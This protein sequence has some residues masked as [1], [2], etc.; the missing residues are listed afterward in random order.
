[1][2]E[3]IVQNLSAPG[4]LAIGDYVF[5]SRWG[6]C[7]WC[8]PW[9]VGHVSEIGLGW[10]SLGE[11]GARRFPKAMR[12][13]HSQGAAI[14]AAYPGLEREKAPLDYEVVAKV[15]GVSRQACEPV[16]AQAEIARLRSALGGLVREYEGYFEGAPESASLTT[17]REALRT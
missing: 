13:T 16:D 9:G 7:D 1:M 4:D 8:D 10:V 6:D 11:T 15:F 2:T 17:A 14:V 3:Q 5:A 12:I